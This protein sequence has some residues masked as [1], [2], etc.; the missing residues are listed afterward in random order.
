MLLSLNLQVKE[1]IVCQGSQSS[2]KIAWHH[3]WMLSKYFRIMWPIFFTGQET[4]K[5]INT[6]QEEIQ[7]SQKDSPQ[8]E[9]SRSEEKSY[10]RQKSQPKI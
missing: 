9:G 3:L 10:S 5:D 8:K 4:Q 6:G 7:A 2:V 1:A